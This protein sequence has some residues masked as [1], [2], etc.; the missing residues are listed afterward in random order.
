MSGSL[1]SLFYVFITSSF[2]RLYMW[3]KDWSIHYGSQHFPFERDK[4]PAITFSQ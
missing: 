3:I 1:E 4:S 2:V